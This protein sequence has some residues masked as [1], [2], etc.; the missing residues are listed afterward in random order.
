M[1]ERREREGERERETGWERGGGGIVS[2]KFLVKVCEVLLMFVHCVCFKGQLVVHTS[3]LPTNG[4]SSLYLWS[5][6][7]LA[8][9]TS[10]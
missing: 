6:A 4:F 2:V 8:F 5:K 7:C 3:T 10:A 9:S 1:R